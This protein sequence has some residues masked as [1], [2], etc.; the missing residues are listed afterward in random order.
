MSDDVVLA[1]ERRKVR[2]SHARSR[3]KLFTEMLKTGGYAA[4]GGGAFEPLVKHAPVEITNIALGAV[5]VVFLA[6]ALYIAPHGD[7]HDGP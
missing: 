3:T 7:A 5:G 1:E 4:F 6:S 2:A